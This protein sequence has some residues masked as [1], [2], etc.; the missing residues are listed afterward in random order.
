[1]PRNDR[2]NPGTGSKA[3]QNRG[4][5][6]QSHLSRLSDSEWVLIERAAATH[7]IPAAGYVRIAAMDA[8]GL[9]GSADEPEPN[10]YN[11]SGREAMTDVPANVSRTART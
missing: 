10:G 8:H 4:D 6:R 3:V 5:M 1:M 11:R 7:G 9:R 2:K